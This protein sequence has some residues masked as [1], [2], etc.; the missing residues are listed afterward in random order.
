MHGRRIG[1]QM[2][3]FLC[4]QLFKGQWSMGAMVF[5]NAESRFSALQY[6]SDFYWALFNVMCTTFGVVAFLW[7]D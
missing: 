3:F 1:Y 6:F 5:A 4:I 2:V 7:L